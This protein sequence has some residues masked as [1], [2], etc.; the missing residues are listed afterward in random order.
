MLVMTEL[1]VGVA[2]GS[3]C[4]LWVR[5]LDDVRHLEVKWTD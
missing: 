5:R 2:E 4:H 3:I 1:W